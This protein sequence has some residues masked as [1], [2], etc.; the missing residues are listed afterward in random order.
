MIL[1]ATLVWSAP[2]VAQEPPPATSPAT[3]PTE[4]TEAPATDSGRLSFDDRVVKGQVAAGSVYLFQR[5]PRALPALVPVRRSY[6]A[7][8]VGPLLAERPKPQTDDR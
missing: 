7:E 1:I 3:P 2:A 4:P 8:I 6:R 5:N